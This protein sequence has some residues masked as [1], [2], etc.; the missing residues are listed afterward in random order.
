[1][2]PPGPRSIRTSAGADQ[3]SELLTLVVDGQRAVRVY[4]P[5]A[6][7]RYPQDDR[8]RPLSNFRYLY[9]R[10]EREVREAG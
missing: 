6:A 9:S 8:V 5:R 4:C 2:G 3:I 10:A 7:R 1:M